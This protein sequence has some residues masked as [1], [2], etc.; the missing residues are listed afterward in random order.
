MDFKTLHIGK[1]IK[2]KVAESDLEISRICSFLKLDEEEVNL[3]YQSANIKTEVLLRWSKLLKYDFFRLYS[4]HLILYSPPQ[5]NNYI[6]KAPHKSKLP[7]FRKN[8]YTQE[9]IDFILELI[10]TEKKTKMEIVEEYRIPKT[11][12]Y[13]WIS[14]NKSK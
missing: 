4:Q 5:G 14:K 7:E 2:K 9:V 6:K 3:M 11:T 13:K 1:L 12:L 8:I 10:Y